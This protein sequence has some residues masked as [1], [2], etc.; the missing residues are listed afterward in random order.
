M[1]LA[2]ENLNVSLAFSHS[3]SYTFR[4]DNPEESLGASPWESQR[5]ARLGLALTNPTVD[6]C[7][8]TQFHI[9]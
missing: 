1:L 2:E 7:V 4:G 5:G 9:R 8:V 3:N 6:L